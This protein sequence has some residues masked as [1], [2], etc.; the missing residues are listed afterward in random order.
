[1]NKLI[2]LTVLSKK[3]I[4]NLKKIFDKEVKLLFIDNEVD[5]IN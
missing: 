3:N 1:M 5:L 2:F 4:H